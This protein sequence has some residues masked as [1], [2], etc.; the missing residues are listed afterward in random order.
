MSRKV[1]GF[2][3]KE[4]NKDDLIPVNSIYIDTIYQVIAYGNPERPIRKTVCIGHRILI[5]KFKK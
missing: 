5:P 3:Y 4:I 2:K 1:V